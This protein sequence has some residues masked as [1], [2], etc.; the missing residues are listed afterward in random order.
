[1]I[2]KEHLSAILERN[3]NTINR[4]LEGISHDESR[5]EPQP[6]G[7]SV[8]WVLGHIVASRNYSLSHLLEQTPFWDE[9][10]AAPYM[11]GSGPLPA[12]KGLSLEALLSALESSQTHLLASLKNMTDSELSKQLKNGTL[13]EQ[14]EFM[15]WHEAYHMGQLGLLRR[16]LGKNGAI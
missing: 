5:H 2:S 6:A 9:S 13:A 3:L 7:N 10:V 15:F 16:L 11:W 4:N 14:L 8:N 12:D 1:M